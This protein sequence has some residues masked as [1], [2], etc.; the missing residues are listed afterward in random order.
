MREVTAQ[1][2]WAIRPSEDSHLWESFKEGRIVGVG[3]RSLQPRS[4]GR[5]MGGKGMGGSFKGSSVSR[6]TDWPEQ[7]R[8]PGTRS[9]RRPAA[10][11][12]SPGQTP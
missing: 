8:P 9:R 10:L 11:L 3:Y 12:P 7:G 2:L 4:S 6:R 5:Q 1:R